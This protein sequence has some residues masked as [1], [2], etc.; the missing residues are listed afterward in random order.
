MW[1][2]FKLW[3]VQDNG[4]LVLLLPEGARCQNCETPLTG[5]FSVIG[6][7]STST[8]VYPPMILPKIGDNGELVL[9]CQKQRC[10]E[11]VLNKDL[12][13]T[14]GMD[15]PKWR[16]YVEEQRTYSIVSRVCD[17]CLRESLSSHRCSGCKAAQYCSSQCQLEDVSFHK[18]VCS[19]FATD[20]L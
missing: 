2:I 14:F 1:P 18:T 16:K 9:F 10:P 5:Q 6:N 3:P 8:N 15:E 12:M 17:F 19:T 20:K 4:E 13:H 7:V 11:K